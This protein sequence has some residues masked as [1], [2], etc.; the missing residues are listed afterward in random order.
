MDSI[1]EGRVDHG[2]HCLAHLYECSG[3]AETVYVRGEASLVTNNSVPEF[4]GTNFTVY[5]DGVG[6]PGPDADREMSPI[7]VEIGP[8]AP[9]SS[10]RGFTG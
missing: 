5:L 10:L 8:K 4:T 9:P 7:P 6:E 2:R 3:F 1:L